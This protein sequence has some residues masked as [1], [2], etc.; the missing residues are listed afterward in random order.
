MGI[1]DYI[2]LGAVLVAIITLIWQVRDNAKQARLQNFTTYTER[3]QKI[4]LNLPIEIE[5]DEF[6]LGKLP[7]DELENTL[8]W[9]RAYFDLCSEEYYLCKERLVAKSVWGLWKSGMIDC[10]R[11]ST[12]KDA[13]SRIQ[14]NQYYS[15]EFEGFIKSLSE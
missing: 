12:Y 11:R 10:F 1:P 7:E 5:T 15:P 3:Y 4:M 6:E 14:K 2:A 13:W 9:L 8:R